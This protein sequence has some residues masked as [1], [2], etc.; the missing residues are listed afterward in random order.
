MGQGGGR[1]AAFHGTCPKKSS[2]RFL[3]LSA[4]F[5]GR[6]ATIFALMASEIER[7]T[8]LL[9]STHSIRETDPQACDD[10]NYVDYVGS[11]S[12]LHG[13]DE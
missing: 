9:M 11:F 5:P 3:A 12:C 10:S 7:P 2:H 1:G 6:I 8:I 13:V 4:K